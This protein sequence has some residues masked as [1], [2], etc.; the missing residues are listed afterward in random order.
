[1]PPALRAAVVE[2]ERGDRGALADVVFRRT[3]SIASV[4]PPAA[5]GRRTFATS[6]S[7]G[8]GVKRNTHT[9]AFDVL[10]QHRRKSLKRNIPL[11]VDH[12]A[13]DLGAR[14]V[15]GSVS[16]IVSA[17]TRPELPAGPILAGPEADERRRTVAH[18]DAGREHRLPRHQRNLDGHRGALWRDARHVVVQGPVEIEIEYA[19]D[20]H[21]RRKLAA[22][23]S[24]APVRCA[25]AFARQLERA[26]DQAAFVDA[27]DRPAARTHLDRARCLREG[28]RDRLRGG[29]PAREPHGVRAGGQRH[30]QRRV[31]FAP[32]G[33]RA[34]RIDADLV[35]LPA[36]ARVRHRHGDRRERAD[37]QRD[38]EPVTVDDD[39]RRGHFR[40][41]RRAGRR[42]GQSRLELGQQL[43][44]G[45]V[46]RLRIRLRRAA[47]RDS[48][49]QDRRE[50]AR[51]RAAARR[52][53]ETTGALV[54]TWSELS[55][56]ALPG[57]RSLPKLN[58]ASQTNSA[59]SAITP[60]RR[61]KNNVTG[62][63]YKKRTESAASTGPDQP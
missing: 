12:E 61:Q 24:A 46:G 19:V 36:V 18:L 35:E 51:G 34:A 54:G 8:R 22:G 10:G 23:A 31:T 4:V 42:R 44:G 26:C 6:F 63:T 39:P 21:E 45:R 38:F 15:F 60:N 49:Q 29:Q 2:L 47:H 62:P 53:R 20:A 14:R 52:C 57:A 33:E 50:H 17:R 11:R 27:A 58:S 5:F 16:S 48:D 13:P 32:H 7:P 59:A 43:A 25:L 41:S 55:G 30:P 1:M 9:G 28:E 37:L 40:T 56:A 3:E